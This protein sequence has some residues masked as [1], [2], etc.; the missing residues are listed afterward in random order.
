MGKKKNLP[1][2]RRSSRLLGL[3]LVPRRPLLLL[4]QLLPMLIMVVWMLAVIVW[5]KEGGSGRNEGEGE[6]RDELKINIVM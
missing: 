6:Q 2:K 4:L 1:I 5:W 3:F